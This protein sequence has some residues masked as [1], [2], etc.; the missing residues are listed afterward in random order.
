M[1]AAM[2]M[3]KTQGQEGVIGR[4]KIEESAYMILNTTAHACCLLRVR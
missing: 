4:F 3:K 2:R 1:C